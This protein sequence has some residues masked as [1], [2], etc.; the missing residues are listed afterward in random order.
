MQEQLMRYIQD[1]H[2]R[3]AIGLNEEQDEFY[4]PLARGEYNVNYRFTH[5]F[6]SQELVLRMNT[7]SQMHLDDQISYEYNALCLLKNSGRTPRV[8]FVDDRKSTIPYGVL[9]MEYLPGAT[10]DY[11]TQ[12]Q[13]AAPCLADIHATVLPEN[14]GLIVPEEPLKA[15]LEE[16]EAMFSVYANS[17]LQDRAVTEQIQKM[18]KKGWN[19]ANNYSGAFTPVIVNTEL[20]STN[21]LVEDGIARLVDWEKPLQSDPAQDLGH[22]LA[23]T[24]TFW[25]TDVILDD[26]QMD[27]WMDAY[28]AAMDGRVDLGNIKE[29]T[30]TF[31]AITCLR[32][33][34][35]C[36]MAWVE[37]QDPDKLIANASTRKK[38]DAYL[39]LSFLQGIEVRF[40]A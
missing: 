3:T 28:I 26:G 6:T 23:P 16:C 36:A 1:A 9:A 13:L 19:I 29:R 27:A 8:Y 14:H 38:L 4:T 18:L 21:F 31:V 17:P 11:D 5:P 20:N 32:G 37:Y 39:D 12:I 40:F 10:L 33:I 25:K 22:F 35:W 15:I 34:T 2:Y 7:A 30:K 24:T